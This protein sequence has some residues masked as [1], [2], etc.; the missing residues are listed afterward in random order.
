MQ[1]VL[2]NQNQAQISGVS[3]TT[4]FQNCTKNFKVFENLSQDYCSTRKNI[5][6][7]SCPEAK[8]SLVCSGLEIW[9]MGPWNPQKCHSVKLWCLP[10]PLGSN[11]D[12][13]SLVCCCWFFF[14]ETDSALC[15]ISKLSRP[16]IQTL[17]TLIGCKALIAMRKEETFKLQKY[18]IYLHWSYLNEIDVQQT[19]GE[20]NESG[21]FQRIRQKYAKANKNKTKTALEHILAHIDDHF[22]WWLV[23]NLLGSSFC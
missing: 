20:P 16:G 14:V 6:K 9:G 22:S 23:A 1:Y 11:Y 18:W 3:E 4:R 5:L 19:T 17:M 2:A 8:H 7:F 10:L 21:T 12:C 15:I 13:Y